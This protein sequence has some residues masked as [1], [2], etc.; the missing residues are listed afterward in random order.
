VIDIEAALEYARRHRL[1]A[2]VVARGDDIISETYGGGFDRNAPHK[3]FSGTKSF[4]GIAAVVAEL[5][6]LLSLDEKV[7]DTIES[8]RSDPWKRRVTYRMLLSL[9]AGH[10]FG[11]LGA[12]VPSYE[13]A[14]EMPLANEPGSTF[15]YTGI[16]LQVFGAAFARKLAPLELTPQQYLTVRV[17]DAAH[18]SVA[19]WRALADT[20]QP[21]PTGAAMNAVNWLAY[22]RYVLSNHASFWQ[23]FRGTAANPNYGLGFWL[24]GPHG[25]GPPDAFYA[26]GSGGQGMY[27]IPELDV[28]A[29][30]FGAGGSYKHDAMLRRLTGRSSKR[31]K[32]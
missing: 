28:V 12:G 6:A 2:F 24:E 1:E 17:L 18:A 3:L 5:E 29:V 7:A 25:D 31:T 32:G 13:R 8:W 23:C 21:L 15:T 4:W 20:T 9:T 22:G 27:C 16:S 30:H 19:A 14:L 10:P 26:S 11:G